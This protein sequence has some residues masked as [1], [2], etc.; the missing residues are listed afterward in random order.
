MSLFS[1]NF[2]KLTAILWIASFSISSQAAICGDA[3]DTRLIAGQDINSGLITISNDEENLYIN[4]STQNPWLL[5]E[6][7]VHLAESVE[8]IPTTRSGNPKIG[9]FQYQQSFDSLLD[10]YTFTIA[11]SDFNWVANGETRV[12]LAAHAVVADVTSVDEIGNI[13]RRETAWGKGESFSGKSWAMYFGYTLQA[14]ETKPPAESN[15]L[16]R[17]QTQGGWGS[18][19]R[20]NNAGA[21][22]DTLFDSVFTNGL[23]IGSANGH[24]V[25]F[26]NS[27][28]VQCFL[29]MGGTPQALSADDFDPALSGGNCVVPQ[30]EYNVLAG[31]VL[32]LTL[33]MEIDT[34]CN[35]PTNN[36]QFAGSDGDSP[37]QLGELLVVEPTSICFSMNVRQILDLANDVLSG[38]NGTYMPAAINTCLSKINENFVDGTINEGFLGLP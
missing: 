25:V 35:E 8:G 28:S 22:R 19:A 13:Q 3:F 7:H 4:F 5:D 1:T 37:V 15:K 12:F 17:T 38:T 6:M 30:I 33:N 26:T 31:Q 2:F 10:T 27:L 23:V 16:W 29:P 36:C 14:C 11:L 24:T 34:H 18:Q 9:R 21:L 32:A 20:G